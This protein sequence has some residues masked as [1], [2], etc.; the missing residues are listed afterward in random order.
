[1]D[2]VAEFIPGWSGDHRRIEEIVH[3]VCDFLG[4][5]YFSNYTIRVGRSE[6]R[7]IPPKFLIMTPQFTFERVIEKNSSEKETVASLLYYLLLLQNGDDNTP[8]RYRRE[9][10]DIFSSAIYLRYKNVF[11]IDPD[12]WRGWARRV[13]R[14]LIA[15]NDANTDTECLI[16]N[17]L[18][19][20]VDEYQMLSLYFWWKSTCICTR[21]EYIHDKTLVIVKYRDH[22]LYITISNRDGCFSFDTTSIDTLLLFYQKMINIH[23]LHPADSYVSDTWIAVVVCIAVCI[24]IIIFFM[25]FTWMNCTLLAIIVIFYMNAMRRCCRPHVE[26]S[27]NHLE[28]CLLQKRIRTCPRATWMDEILRD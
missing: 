17:T 25:I 8:L 21:K 2:L 11:R 10:G 9:Q 6:F 16:E 18:S 12:T 7:W 27:F 19:S 20:C 24:A 26:S 28:R 5:G 14:A 23:H 13:R 22:S 1:M 4:H 3:H 15:L